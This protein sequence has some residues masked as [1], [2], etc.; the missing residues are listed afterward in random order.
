MSFYGLLKMILYGKYLIEQT[1]HTR[2]RETSF[3][4]PLSSVTVL[5]PLIKITAFWKRLQWHRTS[6]FLYGDILRCR[7]LQP[8]RGRTCAHTYLGPCVL[9]QLRAA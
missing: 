5:C 3:I 9:S 6:I 2:W 8:G 1:I 4:I 7:I